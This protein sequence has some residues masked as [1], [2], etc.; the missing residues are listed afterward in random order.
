[1]ARRT[2]V[3]FLLTNDFLL[4]G[5]TIELSSPESF[6]LNPPSKKLKHKEHEL[7][8]ASLQIPKTSIPFSANVL[9]DDVRKGT[10][11]PTKRVVR[12]SKIWTAKIQETK[13]LREKRETFIFYYI[14]SGKEWKWISW[15]STLKEVWWRDPAEESRRRREAAFMM[16]W[17]M[18]CGRIEDGSGTRE[19]GWGGGSADPICSIHR[20]N[21][22]ASLQLNWRPWLS[23]YPLH[24]PGFLS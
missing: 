18:G 12:S 5:P 22:V 23:S 14:M 24:T 6:L 13:K 19:N 1:M 11:C 4:E 10:L 15:I 9:S 21:A 3:Q 2:L 8:R 16:T 20:T 7:S 17:K